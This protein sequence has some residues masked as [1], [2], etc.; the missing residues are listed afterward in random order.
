MALF[1]FDTVPHAVEWGTQWKNW[2][3]KLRDY[4][5]EFLTNPQFND[6]TIDDDL[7]VGGDVAVTGTTTTEDLVVNDDATITDTLTL[8]G[9]VVRLP[10]L[11][12]PVTLSG[13]STTLTTTI[14][15]WARKVIITIVGASTN[16][17]S[18]PVFRIGP[19]GGTVATGYSGSG[20]KLS[21]AAAVVSAAETTGFR[22]GTDHAADR[23]IHGIATLSLHDASTNTWAYSYISGR[24]TAGNEVAGGSIA[25]SGSLARIIATTIGGV[26]TFDGGT[27]SVR[28]EY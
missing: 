17:T 23:M 28:Y 10:V 9:V 25:L 2:V 22:F 11:E 20:T 16:G 24:T 13:T 4:L 21:D 15:T 18:A 14:P 8:G 6:V 3:A 27:M 26:N 7:T 5:I 1:S 19:S 12:S